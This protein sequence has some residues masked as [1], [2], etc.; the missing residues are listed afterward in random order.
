MH[1]I[2]VLLAG[3]FLIGLCFFVGHMTSGSHPFDLAIKV[4]LPLWLLASCVN[5]YVGVKH[6]GY[7]FSEETSPFLIVFSIPA[8]LALLLWWLLR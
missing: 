5:M 8:C 2:K 7:A 4:F 1:T 3:L 6:A